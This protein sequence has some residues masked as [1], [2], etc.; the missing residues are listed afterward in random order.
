MIYDLIGFGE[1]LKSIRLEMKLRH[2]DVTEIACIERDTLRRLES[3]K[4]LP[5]ISTLDALSIVYK[6]D[7]Y[8]LFKSYK[9]TPM[10]LMEISMDEINPFIRNLDFQGVKMTYEAIKGRYSPTEYEIFP[11]L[12]HKLNL[13]WEY[14]QSLYNMENAF[15]DKSRKDLSKLMGALGYSL[16]KISLE[17]PN[18]NLDLLEIR[19]FVLIGII[20]RYRKEID[21]SELFLMIALREIKEKHSTSRKFLYFYLL[22]STNLMMTYH[23]RDRYKEI[24]K[25]FDESVTVLDHELGMINISTLFIR[26]GVNNYNQSQDIHSEY[27][28]VAI[29]LLSHTQYTKK[30]EHIDGNL[31]KIYDFYDPLFSKNLTEN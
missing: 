24:K 8:M 10:E 6:R 12:H 9:L 19:V 15:V 1:K 29:D 3:G 23:I 7:I 31:G 14:I 30:A 2:V 18:L 25:L 26:N 5:K 17:N 13:L 21:Y 11:P 4:S 16:E 27:L 28:R 22:T 20:Y